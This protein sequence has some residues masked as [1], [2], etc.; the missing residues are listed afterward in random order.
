MVTE[1]TGSSGRLWRTSDKNTQAANG[2]AAAG[3]R[4]ADRSRKPPTKT[5]TPSQMIAGSSAGLPATAQ[6]LDLASPDKKE[7]AMRLVSSAEN[8]SL[9]WRAQFAYIEDIGDGRGYTAGIIG[10]C[11]GTG[12]MLKLVEKYTATKPANSLAVFLPA[13][14]A[15]NGSASHDGLG[16]AFVAAWKQAAADPV[17]QQSQEEL[18]DEVYFKPAI[19]LAKTDG[20]STLG[21]F[22]YYDAAVMHGPD[23]WG[24]GL[25]DIRAK[26][27]AVA[28]P[29]AQG[30]DEKVYLTAFLDARKVEMSKEAAHRDLSRINSAQ[31]AFLQAGNL[32]LTPPL[33]WNM[34]GDNF[35][36]PANP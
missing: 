3:A 34:Y 32:T 36:I 25:Q 8:S 31:L 1:S 26:A 2:S 10:F 15:V 11:S 30:G 13:L 18:R 28:K 22:M 23:A 16:D 9:D 19:A 6:I 35:T 20:L 14:R 5:V 27:V 29:P 24:G 4:R 17:F 7:I 12:D 33:Q 21:Q